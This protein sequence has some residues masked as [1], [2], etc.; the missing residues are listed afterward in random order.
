TQISLALSLVP[1]RAR[2]QAQ[3]INF[4]D[5]FDLAGTQPGFGLGKLPL[6]LG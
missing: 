5:W 3:K 2:S 1:M 4:E 6:G